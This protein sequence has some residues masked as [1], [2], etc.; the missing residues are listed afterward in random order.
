MRKCPKAMT[1]SEFKWVLLLLVTELPLS[2]SEIR[3]HMNIPPGICSVLR[4][5]CTKLRLPPDCAPDCWQNCAPQQ[6]WEHCNRPTIH[7]Q[8]A[9]SFRPLHAVISDKVISCALLCR[10]KWYSWHRSLETEWSTAYTNICGS[11]LLKVHLKGSS[12]SLFLIMLIEL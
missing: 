11:R 8:R 6:G 5:L 1:E 10:A 9:L 12:K 7:E 4:E 3:E 2:S